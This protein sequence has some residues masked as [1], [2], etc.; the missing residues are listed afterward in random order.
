[1]RTLYLT[2]MIFCHILL[3]SFILYSTLTSA[4]PVAEHQTPQK[5]AAEPPKNAPV[6]AVVAEKPQEANQQQQ[7]QPMHYAAAPKA[8]QKPKGE[9]QKIEAVAEEKDSLVQK[10]SAA[11][12]PSVEDAK[13]VETVEKQPQKY[14]DPQKI[15]AHEHVGKETPLA[16]PVKQDQPIHVVPQAAAEQVKPAVAFKAPIEQPVVVAAMAKVEEPQRH[17]WLP[18]LHDG[19]QQKPIATPPEPVVATGAKAEEAHRQ[20]WVPFLRDGVQEKPV[21]AQPEPVV[22]VKQEASPTKPAVQ[23]IVASPAV[24]GAPVPEI[25]KPHFSALVAPVVSAPVV[26]GGLGP[27][28]LLAATLCSYQAPLKPVSSDETLSYLYSQR[29]AQRK[30]LFQF[31]SLK[32][33]NLD[34]LTAQLNAGLEVAKVAADSSADSSLVRSH[35]WPVVGNCTAHYLKLMAEAAWCDCAEEPHCLRDLQEAKQSPVPAQARLARRSAD[36]E[37]SSSVIS[38]LMY[39]GDIREAPLVEAAQQPN[40]PPTSVQPASVAP[41]RQC[42]RNALRLAKALFNH[43]AENQTEVSESWPSL[44]AELY[45][46]ECARKRMIDIVTALS[47]FRSESTQVHRDNIEFAFAMDDLRGKVLENEVNTPLTFDKQ[48]IEVEQFLQQSVR[49]MLANIDPKRAK[50]TSMR[51]RSLHAPVS[52]DDQCIELHQRLLAKNYPDECN[53]NQYGPL[54]DVLRMTALS[55]DLWSIEQDLAKYSTPREAPKQQEVNE[56][57]AN[58]VAN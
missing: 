31:M 54:P 9:Q 36:E 32:F 22:V 24:V 19:V 50:L 39:V 21:A 47:T 57:I 15:V 13:P 8:E 5:F 58:L 6:V 43:L 38:K 7:Q 29:A 3:S 56:C 30:S 16:A 23:Q 26:K 41:T 48:V 25:S 46:D 28:H 17:Q 27:L 20:Q 42:R 33:T 12:K 10:S 1:M 35:G 14:I 11:K 49:L 45:R 34:K 2:T 52:A 40:K 37:R 55:L 44:S 4:S 53:P 18:F 51:Y